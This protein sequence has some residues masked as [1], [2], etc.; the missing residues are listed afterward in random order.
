[1]KN[2]YRRMAMI[3]HKLYIE[4]VKFPSCY[5]V[6]DFFEVVNDFNI[7]QLSPHFFKNTSILHFLPQNSS[8]SGGGH[9]IYNIL[10]PYPTD[11]TFKIWSRLVQ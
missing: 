8:P 5:Y 9:E 2:N 7:Y 4:F 10:S 3:L 1:M 6:I 11:P